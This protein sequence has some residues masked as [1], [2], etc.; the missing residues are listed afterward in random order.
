MTKGGIE[1]P[2]MSAKLT[3]AL[4]RATYA[5]NADDAFNKVFSEYLELKLNQLQQIIERL[6]GKWGMSF[7]EFK[8]KI[9]NNTLEKDAYSFDTETDFWEWEEAET[10]REHYADIKNQ[11]M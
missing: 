9:K 11:W 8:G 1:M 2:V 7:E 3:D 6:R 4:V 10:L 5:R